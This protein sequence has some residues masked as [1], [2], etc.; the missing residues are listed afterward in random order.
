MRW[1]KRRTSKTWLPIKVTPLNFPSIAGVLWMELFRKRKGGDDRKRIITQG[2][3]TT[4]RKGLT[5]G[6]EKR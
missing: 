4:A 1:K 2:S 5:P 6:M 3:R